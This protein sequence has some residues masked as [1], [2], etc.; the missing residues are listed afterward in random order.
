MQPAS[1]GCLNFVRVF[2]GRFA[3]CQYPFRGK[4]FD[5]QVQNPVAELRFFSR[6]CAV[7]AGI[8]GLVR[9][10]REDVPESG[11][12]GAL[13]QV[14]PN[15]GGSLFALRAGGAQM[16]AESANKRVQVFLN[17]RFARERYARER[18]ARVTG[19]FA[20]QQITGAGPLNQ[21]LEI[22]PEIFALQFMAIR[23]RHRVAIGITL[24]N[25]QQI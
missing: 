18:A 3:D 1:N 24:Q 9:V 6:R 15:D 16:R 12:G 8:A 4:D 13:R 21:R 14:I 7:P 22:G 2:A 19:R 17:H 20:H 25:R 10:K 11:N 23:I 5:N